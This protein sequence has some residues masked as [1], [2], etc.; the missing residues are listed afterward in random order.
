MKGS[1]YLFFIIIILFFI[2]PVIAFS[3][4]YDEMNDAMFNI[5]CIYPSKIVEPGES[6]SFNMSFCNRAD[7]MLTRPIYADIEK[8]DKTWRYRFRSDDSEIDRISLHP[9]ECAGVILEVDTPEGITP[10]SYGIRTRIQSARFWVYVNIVNKGRFAISCMYPGKIIEAGEKAV[11]N[12]TFRNNA[13]TPLTRPLS[14]NISKEEK[15]WRYRF[16]EGNSNI[17]R[18]TLSPGEEAMVNLEVQTSGETPMGTYPVI[19]ESGSTQSKIDIT[20]NQSHAGDP[21]ILHSQILDEL[22]HPVKGAKIEIIPRNLSSPIIVIQTTSDGQVRSGF[23]QGDYDL[24]ISKDGYQGIRKDNI[25]L[26]S[27]YT[28]DLGTMMLERKNYG[29]NIDVK[30]PTLSSVVGDH[31]SFELTLKNVGKSDDTYRLGSNQTPSGWFIRY[32]EGANSTATVSEVFIRSGEEKQ[33][34]LQAIPPYTIA[35]GSYNLTSMI[36]ATEGSY[37]QPLRAIILGA[38]DLQVS[39]EKYRYEII[40]GEDLTIPV[41]IQNKGKGETLSNIQLDLTV[42][43][44]W[45][46]NITPKTISSI[47]P[48]ADEPVILKIEPLAGTSA[49]E[50]KVSLNIV[51]DQQKKTEDLMVIIREDMIF[52]YIGLVII[53]LILFGVYYFFKKYERR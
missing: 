11:F 9:N 14:L 28:T 4:E 50:Y 49:S 1:F 2:H 16:F 39:I 33:L 8:S 12:L 45:R 43:Q 31:P 30:S 40:R 13:D 21:G 44:G 52:M 47:E 22:G 35:K 46:S 51:S 15:D 10:G 42:P 37:L 29:L 48:G 25:Y 6:V 36:N 32:L 20:L 18:L 19:I 27:G 26:T 38:A 5:S 23:K 24:K 17:D 53:S 7:I 41:K 34:Y 3:P